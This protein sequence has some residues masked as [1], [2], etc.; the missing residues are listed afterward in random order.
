MRQLF[1]RSQLEISGEKGENRLGKL[2]SLLEENKILVNFILKI[3]L[4]LFSFHGYLISV[5]IFFFFTNKYTDYFQYF[6]VRFP[7]NDKIVFWNV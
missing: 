6:R 5:N 3:T 4:L 2:E 7:K 1:G